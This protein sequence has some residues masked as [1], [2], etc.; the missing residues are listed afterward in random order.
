[1][2]DDVVSRQ[3][4]TNFRDRPLNIFGHF[5][6][7]VRSSER[8]ENVGGLML[9]LCL[10]VVQ[11]NS[12]LS[13][14]V[15]TDAGSDDDSIAVADQAA[16]FWQLPAGPIWWC[17]VWAGHPNIM[18]WLSHAQWLHP[19]ISSGLRDESRLISERMKHLFYEV[20]FLETPFQKL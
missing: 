5:V 12:M 7:D 6:E 15:L 20:I 17:H 1:M 3:R 10:F 4:S 14:D 8:G 2:D 11:S 13:E 9:K 18:K 16:P 19:A